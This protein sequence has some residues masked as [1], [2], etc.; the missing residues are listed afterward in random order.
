VEF[1]LASNPQLERNLQKQTAVYQ[2]ASDAE[3]CIKIIIFFSR[4]ERERVERI[5]KRLKLEKSD[6]VVLIDARNDN[7]PSGSK[8]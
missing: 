1:K 7:K 6:D 8:A 2:K 3:R 5:L 4:S